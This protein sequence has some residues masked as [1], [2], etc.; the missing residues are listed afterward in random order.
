MPSDKEYKATKQIMLGKATINFDFRQLADFIDQ[1]FGVKTINIIYDTFGKEKQPRLNICFEFEREKQ[2]FNDD[3]GNFNFDNKKQKVIVNKFKQTLEEQK[4]IE[5]KGFF[6]FFAKTKNEKYKTDNVWVCYS[7]FE[8]IARHEAI[9]NI[10]ESKVIQLKKELDN[11]YLWEISK[12]FGGTTFFLHT[13]EQVKLYENSETRKVWANKYFD[14]L[15]QYNE[16]GY[17]K[18]EMFNIYLDSKE[19]FDRNYESNWYYYYK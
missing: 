2:S 17:F 6:G 10:P 13:D 7:A 14:I 12:A 1:T 8:P 15:E 9:D 18:R 3:K 11:K 5:K 19:N 4:I 16:F